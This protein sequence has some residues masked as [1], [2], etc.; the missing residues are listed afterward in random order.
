MQE[1]DAITNVAVS[2]IVDTDRQRKNYGDIHG[3]ATSI[4]KF[5]IIQPIVLTR[6]DSSISLVAG[7][8]RLAA[9]R[10]LGLTNLVHARDFV[11]RE[12]LSDDSGRLQLQAV[13][14]EENLRRSDLS[15]SETIAAK[16]KL[17]AL[18]QS[19]HGASKGFGV[20]RSGT[21]GFGIRTLA[22]MLD[23]NPSTT[24]RDIELA[25][26]VAKHPMLAQMPTKADAQRKLGVA[27]TVA[28]M[29]A[30][31]KRSVVTPSGDLVSTTVGTGGGSQSPSQS[32]VPVLLPAHDER[33]TLYEG[34]FQEK[35]EMVPDNSVDLV[36][37]DLPYNIGLGN[38]TASHSAGL[39]QFDDS[40]LDIVQLCSDVAVQAF[41]LMRNDRFAVFFYGMN[42]HG[43]FYDAL[44][45]AGFTVDVYPFIWLRDRS[46]PP[47]GFA[48]YSKTYDPAFIASKG[49][50][51]FI[52]P[53]LPNSLAVSSVR[54]AERLH[55]A[56]KPL[57][58]MQKFIEDMTT[59]GC[60]VLDMFAGAGTTGVAA[61]RTG[62]KAILFEMEQQNCTLIKSRLG[63]L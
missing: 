15:W 19:I 38:S 11:W 29:Q 50:P 9:C 49:V 41:R 8:R 22:A 60:V 28:A 35:I 10:Y 55:A 23:E 51:R 3:L 18:M 42:Y 58:I 14:L 44:T 5:G 4:K 26:Y 33:W 30:I 43:V 56:Q 54:G 47:D 39:G 45:T 17:M 46:A 57:A 20:G 40:D 59:P 16:A 24:S 61:L 37:T 6:R 31:A 21:D 27:V 12:E 53:N 62:R 25:G 36:L 7:G 63:V 1:S 48:R 13:E 2:N 34:R 32:P 52:R